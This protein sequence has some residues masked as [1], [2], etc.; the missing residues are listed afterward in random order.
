MRLNV[1]PVPLPCRLLVTVTLACVH[2][3]CRMVLTPG[4]EQTTGLCCTLPLCLAQH[5]DSYWYVDLCAHLLSFGAGARSV[6]NFRDTPLHLAG[7]RAYSHVLS[8]LLDEAVDMHALS[9]VGFTPLVEVIDRVDRCDDD[10]AERQAACQSLV[11]Y[12]SFIVC[13][14]DWHC[15]SAR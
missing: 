8:L 12:G 3:S 11:A 15:C 9:K 13:A 2:S 5:H 4:H 7:N 10:P 1:V 14:Q 6:N